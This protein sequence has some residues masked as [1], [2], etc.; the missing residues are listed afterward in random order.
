MEL[1]SRAA[2]DPFQADECSEGNA[3]LTEEKERN[4]VNTALPKLG[5][6]A[7][8]PHTRVGVGERA[9]IPGERCECHGVHQDYINQLKSERIARGNRLKKKT[10]LLQSQFGTKPETPA[11]HTKTLGRNLRLQSV[12]YARFKKRTQ[13]NS[14]EADTPPRQRPAAACLATNKYKNNYSFWIQNNIKKFCFTFG[15]NINK[16]SLKTIRQN[17]INC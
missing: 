10:W 7:T 14:T 3:L 4:K 6:G 15:K 17:I 9:N 8:G 2:K 11:F 16:H 12:D 13:L 5:E 1:E